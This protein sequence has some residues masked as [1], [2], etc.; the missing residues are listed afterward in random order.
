MCI[1]VINN[2]D[3]SNDK[4]SNND[5]NKNNDKN[6]QHAMCQVQHWNMYRIMMSLYIDYI[7]N[8]W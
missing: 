3:N 1:Y 6:L 5:N 8:L 2:H 4:N 7:Y